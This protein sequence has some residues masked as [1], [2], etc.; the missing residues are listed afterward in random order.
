MG[1]QQ[2]WLTWEE[3]LRHMTFY[4]AVYRPTVLRANVLHQRPSS[5][6]S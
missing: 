6:R 3:P 1:R 4:K 5:R 2:G